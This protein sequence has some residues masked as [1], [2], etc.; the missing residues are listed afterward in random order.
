MTEEV[1]VDIE[2]GADTPAEE[3]PAADAPAPEAGVQATVQ[4][5]PEP[6]PVKLV[7]ATVTKPSRESLVG[8]GVVDR[9]GLLGKT[10]PVIN[11]IKEG[12]LCAGSDLEVGMHLYSINGVACKGRDDATAM[13]KVCEGSITIKA[14]PPGLIW[15]TVVKE[16]ADQKVGLHME[17]HKN[18][19]RVI[20][21]SVKGLFAETE[22]KDG[23]TI[24]QINE[25]DI[26]GR[27]MS[28]VLAMVTEAEGKITVMAQAPQD[29]SEKILGHPP[30]E[31]LG[32]GQ[33]G[34]TSYVGAQTGAFAIISLITVVGWAII[35][36]L[37]PSDWMDVYMVDGKLYTP[38][39]EFFKSATKHNFEV[40][41]S[42][43]CTEKVKG[44]WGTTTYLGP[45]TWSCAIMATPTFFIGTVFILLL[46]PMDERDVYLANGNLYSP[47]GKFL[48]TA[49]NRNFT[50]RKSQ[51][52]QH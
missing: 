30:P 20:V 49:T 8:L 29:L 12:S 19:R 7:I 46:L 1:E 10:V 23:M 51:H 50:L 22:L 44:V 15:A 32:G 11:T 35:L 43:H 27:P 31:G 6:E 5:V 42:E 18:S 39:G 26:E 36:L 9:P 3:A 48:K 14:G 52:L 34:S 13:L 38:S 21:G 16:S 17:R 45:K 28:E 4:E 40:R 2:T 25:Q 24:V 47:S 33:W 41:K 37:L